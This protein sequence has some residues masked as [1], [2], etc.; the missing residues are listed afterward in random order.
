[1]HVTQSASFTGE[2]V[3]FYNVADYG[4]EGIAFPA[5][6]LELINFSYKWISYS[7]DTRETI[8]HPKNGAT[9]DSIGIQKAIDDAH[10]SGGGTVF[11]PPG[12][13][14][15]A[16]L[17]LKS[18][19]RL[20]L[21]AGARLWASPSLEDYVNHRGLPEGALTFLDPARGVD[22]TTPAWPGTPPTPGDPLNLV[23][24][25]DAEDV[26][27]TGAGEIHGQS[28]HWII[29]WMNSRPESWASLN[30]RR[31]G[32]ALVLFSNC[33]HVLVEGV[34]IY[35]SPSWT[36]VFSRCRHVRASGVFI[37]NFDAINA[38]GIDLV[39]TSN[40]L[41]SDC[42]IHCTD[43]GICLKTNPYDSSPPGVHNVAVNNCIIRT[44]CNGVK[45]GTE[46]SGI[47]ENITFSNIVVYSPD[48][49]L[50]EVEA[51]I[52]VCCCDGG[53]VR[54]VRF[55][56]FVLRNARCAF[57]L[58]TTPRKKF[59]CGYREPAAGQI[60]RISIS[61]VTAD[62]VHYTSF[63]VGSPGSPIRDVDIRN[64][65]VR[66]THE[67]RPGSFP[68]PVRV[69]CEQYPNPFM[70]GSPDGGRQDCGDG[71]PASG[72]YFR[73]VER[74]VVRDFRLDCKEPDGRETIVIESCIG[75]DA[76]TGKT[77]CR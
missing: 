42:D 70:F 24:A 8:Y 64:I 63:V 9:L 36:L 56:G 32:A 69:C 53:T 35:D 75:V 59:Q 23:F 37:R 55:N 76:T 16:P 68:E 72:L 67:F 1:M 50:R 12:D 60:E 13:Y 5:E 51:G 4:A 48:D 22:G 61:D 65:F 21:E 28:A 66:K 74:A 41:I 19:V 57:Y 11:V 43:D 25:L 27:I 73:D 14:L 45:I 39:D 33:R 3:S 29:P 58:V 77:V 6:E 38:D 47:F 7:K 10:A 30:G 54:N 31:P 40:V 2:R 18:R 46:T 62:G 15:I 49:D 20:H 34:R 52:N 71:L 26:S 44:W 17:E